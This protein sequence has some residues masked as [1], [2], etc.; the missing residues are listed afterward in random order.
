[1]IYSAKKFMVRTVLEPV[2][3]YSIPVILISMFTTLGCLAA[4]KTDNASQSLDVAVSARH[5]AKMPLMIG[6]INGADAMKSAKTDE[7]S[8]AYFVSV[9][10][11]DLE[12]SG[13]FAVTI[14]SCGQEPDRAALQHLAQQGFPLAIFLECEKKG[15]TIKWRLYDTE[16]SKME[17]GKR[18]H[19]LD[20]IMR[21]W[22]HNVA[23]ELWVTLT[24]HDG[25]FS[26][27]IAY[28]KEVRAKNRRY[29]HICVADYDGSHEQFLVQTPTINLAPRWNRTQ[30][31]PLLFYSESTNTNV[32]LM[33]A[34]MH[35]KRKVASG[36]DG[37]NMVPAFSGHGDKVVYCASRGM[38]NCQLY[39]YTNNALKLVTNNTGNNVSPT[40]S[41]DGN[42][43]F[44]CSDF[45]G[46]PSIYQYDFSTKAQ[47]RITNDSLA[48][49]PSY[50]DKEGKS[51]KLAYTKIVQGKTQIFLYEEK[52][53]THRQLTFDAQ[54]KD[55]CSWSPCGNYVLYSSSQGGRS[56]LA[57][58]N[59]LTGTNQF[60]TAAHDDCS[61]PTWSGRYAQ[62]PVLMQ[63][64]ET[65]SA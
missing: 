49:C 20:G 3:N 30:G 35:G 32:R 65:A 38:G 43:L 51:G 55:E 47:T 17:L 23:D 40:L 64:K 54:N 13:Q 46:N 53:G 22:A 56:R 29:K 19:K 52:K 57:V 44:F 62:F 12:F 50:W 39:S 36:F 16:Q 59:V 7:E 10:K 48:F 2:R 9:L 42:K 41:S 26:T 31:N 25:F 61:Y 34:N 15:A 37:I 58:H 24:G 18:S 60:I 45:Q 11:K 5:H 8:F 63:G 33:W 27:K 21:G 6:V 1:M 28:A 4:Q 14:Q